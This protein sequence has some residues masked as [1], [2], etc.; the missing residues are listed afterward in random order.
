M[1]STST[2]NTDS[3]PLWGFPG[4]SR[5]AN[6]FHALLDHSTSTHFFKPAAPE[7]RGWISWRH[8]HLERFH[9]LLLSPFGF[10]QLLLSSL[11]SFFSLFLFFLFFLYVASWKSDV[12]FSIVEK[13]ISMACRYIRRTLRVKSFYQDS[14]VA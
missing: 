4:V 1:L 11:L 10:L 14:V 9:V 12:S 3:R 6:T 5:P 2:T 7:H 8:A 13:R